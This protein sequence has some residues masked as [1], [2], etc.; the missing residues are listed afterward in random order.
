MAFQFPHSIRTP[1]RTG[2]ECSD[3]PQPAIRDCLASHGARKV[4]RYEGNGKI[5]GAGLEAAATKS[6]TRVTRV[7]LLGLGLGPPGVVRWRPGPDWELTCGLAHGWQLGG[8]NSSCARAA[9]L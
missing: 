5:E 9:R 2:S 8:K 1:L 4:R 7:K 3:D 6:K